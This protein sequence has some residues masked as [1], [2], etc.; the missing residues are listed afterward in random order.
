MRYN[1][2]YIRESI[3]DQSELQDIELDIRDDFNYDDYKVQMMWFVPADKTNYMKIVENFLEHCIFC[4]YAIK[5]SSKFIFN[6]Y[7]ED[8]LREKQADRLFNI[9]TKILFIYE[10]VEFYGVM[11][12]HRYAPPLHIKSR[13]KIV[14]LRSCVINGNM[15]DLRK[16]KLSDNIKELYL[17]RIFDEDMTK[18]I[19]Y[20]DITGFDTSK[21]NYITF[22]DFKNLKEIYGIGDIDVSNIKN[23]Y[24]M[25]S[26]C[27]SLKKLDISGW[28]VSD[29]ECM[30][31]M[32]CSCF[33]L[34]EL[35]ISRW[36]VSKVNDMVYMFKNCT[37]LETLDVCGWNVSNVE[38]MEC[39]FNG[40]S[41]L[42]ELDVSKWNV[43]KVKDMTDMFDNTN[44]KF[45]GGKPSWVK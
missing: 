36:N 4:D 19:E 17:L 8:Y 22:R 26:D 38:N 33:S 34:E 7:I 5:Q 15:L 10:A 12:G 14:L 9:M 25:F 24:C 3:F 31:S 13:D 32:F 41:S 6:V 30:S 28:N 16:V 29:I 27:N 1:D 44:I 23:M 39:M 40:C 18:Q 35:D 11:T 37:S 20:I 42:K 2:R 45:I 21:L 43:S